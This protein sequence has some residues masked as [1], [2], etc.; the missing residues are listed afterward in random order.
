MHAE[1]LLWSDTKQHWM[2]DQLI[3]F[4]YQ[5]EWNMDQCPLPRKKT[6]AVLDPARAFRRKIRFQCVSPSLAV[7]L[8][9]ACWQ[10][11]FRGE[12]APQAEMY[13]YHIPRLV[14]WLNYA[15][16]HGVSLLQNSL[17]KWEMSLRSYLVEQGNWI[18][19]NRTHID[20]SQQLR[21]YEVEDRCMSMLRQIY[22]IV[23][24]TYDERP[25]FDKDKWDLRK[26]GA[27]LNRSKS[28]YT[29]NFAPLTQPWLLQAAKQGMRYEVAVHSASECA[30]KLAA[31]KAFSRFL[32]KMHPAA[33]AKDINRSWM[34]E[35]FQFLSSCELSEQT[36]AGYLIALRTFLEL[37][38]RE[39]WAQISERRLIYDDDLPHR[40]QSHPRY[41]PNEV[42]LQLNQHIELFPVPIMRMVLILQEAGMRISELCTMPFE[43]L[44]QDASG[45]WF[46]R[47][48]QAKMSKEHSIPLTRESVAV[49]QEQQQ[50]VRSEFGQDV[51]FLF[52]NAEGQP[53]KQQT[54]VRALNRL[55]YQKKICN[56]AGS[57][58]NFQSHQFRHTVGTRMINN[59]VP[60]HIVQRYLGHESP[61]M[62]AR[63]T[64]IHDQTMKEEY[65][66]FRGKVVDVTGNVVEENSSVDSNDFQW[67]KKNV[68]AQALPNGK[69][70]LPL[71]AGDCPHANACLTCVHFRTDGSFLPQ[72]K[73]QLQET[74]QL[75]QVARA[76]GWK[77]QV[78]MNER[79]KVNLTRMITALEGTV[80]NGKPQH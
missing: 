62:T 69:C 58:Y 56:A 66:K 51:A 70:A 24:E 74:Q 15:A 68:L 60:Q 65:A 76:N 37:C 49:I 33:E 52:P 6:T 19:S 18:D 11:F 22:H 42:L 77:R 44:M 31:I 36:R 57:P 78:E 17:E 4:W 71:V 41:I 48:Y 67:F 12:W 64:F 25:E 26:L 75:I 5:D 40:R 54:F 43:C 20:A 32:S 39:G 7:E 14:A 30:S 46:L 50:A 59:G 35:Y 10:K 13:A 3:G 16:P 73:V 61:E 79:V 53:L 63:Y 23:K 80:Q 2:R 38:A 47:Y 29:L 27:R 55:A 9:Y 8:K 72:H 45:D 28:D 21:K 34:I 1:A